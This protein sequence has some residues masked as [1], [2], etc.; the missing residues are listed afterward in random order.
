M[1]DILFILLLALVIFGPRKVPEIAG[2]IGKYLAQF[3]RLK[4]EVLDQINGEILLL[5]ERR[6][7]EQKPDTGNQVTEP[8]A[9]AEPDGLTG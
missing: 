2:Q 9:I 1:P 7:I 4:S 5:E 6:R 8:V 3:M